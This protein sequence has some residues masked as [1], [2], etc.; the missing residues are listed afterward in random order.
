MADVTVNNPELLR[1]VLSE[2][3]AL[4]A[5]FVALRSAHD[6]RPTRGKYGA[7]LTELAN[8]DLP[9]M[10]LSITKFTNE[11]QASMQQ[12]FEK[13][14]EKSN[15]DWKPSVVFYNDAKFLV[16]FDADDAEEKF[17]TYILRKANISKSDL[18]AITR[19]LDNATK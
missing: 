17:E 1:D 18:A 15:I 8:S 6:N 10:E 7:A 13:A 2:V 11:S 19:D 16:N 9:L 14:A 5:Q 12:Q 4:K 3:E